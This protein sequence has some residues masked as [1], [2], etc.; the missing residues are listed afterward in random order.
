MER[1][2]FLRLTALAVP[3]VLLAANAGPAQAATP[4]LAP[5]VTAAP[6]ALKGF[7]HGG[8]GKLADGQ[9]AALNL[10]W[11]YG[12]SADCPGT[13]FKEFVPMIW[14]G[15]TVVQS[16]ATVKRELRATKATHLLGFNEPDLKSSSYK[17][18]SNMSVSEAIR[19]WPKL[20]AAGL[21]LG[22]PATIKPNAAW[23]DQ[24]MIK[25]ERAG[26]RIDFMPMHCYGWPDP[27]DFLDKVAKLHEKYQ[28]PVWVTE[29]AVADWDATAKRK[30]E[31][32]VKQVSAF[33]QETVAG[34]RE[35]PFVERFAWKTRDVDDRHMGTSALFDSRGW[36]TDLGR[37]YASL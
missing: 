20:E 30:N 5:A 6:R 19:L 28:R 15:G 2:N 36:R 3:G 8:E 11:G 12:W 10:D 29:Y 22:A 9:R 25:A 32:S 37:L 18:Q 33:M 23:L 1:R 7:G 34:M 24:F 17:Q 4:R 26:L 14:G 31:Y 21:R 35:M 16:V 27:D 13:G